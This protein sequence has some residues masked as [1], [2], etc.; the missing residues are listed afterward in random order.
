MGTENKFSV[1]LENDGG[2]E[3]LEQLQM[4]PNH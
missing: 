2:L 4:H 1:L 3:L